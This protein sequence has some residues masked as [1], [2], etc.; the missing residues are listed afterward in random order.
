[1]VD[2]KTLVVGHRE[3]KME[4]TWK[5]PSSWKVLGRLLGRK[6]VSVLTTKRTLHVITQTSRQEK[7]I[8]EIM[9][10]LSRGKQLLS[11]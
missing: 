1:M 3:I 10:L 6:D 7:P 2:V 5:L 8:G 9:A 11:D 4:L